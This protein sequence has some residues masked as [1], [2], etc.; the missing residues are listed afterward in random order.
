MK[1]TP[2][3]LLLMALLAAGVAAARQGERASAAGKAVPVTAA[4]R[5]K[6]SKLLPEAR[7]LNATAEPA[8]FYASDLYRYIDG[9][10]AI[11]HRHGLVALVH[12][13]YKPK[14]AEVTV[15]IYDLGNDFNAF[16]IYAV[17]RSPASHFIAMGA[18]GYLDANVL[19]FVQGPYYIK[20]S[21]FSGNQKMEPVM[22]AFAQDISRRIGTGKSLPAKAER[23]RE[24]N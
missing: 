22:R 3:L 20:L 21:A 16:G 19:N 8:R 24:R 15:D 13:E 2:A 11:Y 1:R 5:A 14:D 18:E 7:A 9:G 23:A 6:L 10:A 12:R 17:E 4:E